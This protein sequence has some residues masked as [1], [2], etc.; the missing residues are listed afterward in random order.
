MA[1]IEQT[2][3]EGLLTFDFPLGALSSK[4]DEWA[5]YRR[6][7]NKSFG[8][9]KAVDIVFADNAVGWLIE[10]KDYRAHSRTKAID[11]AD[12]IA[13]KVR[14]TL[15][16]L[17]SANISANDADEKNLASRLLLC[18]RLRVVLHIEQ[19]ATQSK[20]RPTAI[21]PAAVLLKLKGRVKS[22][23][24]YPCVVDQNSLKNAMSWTVQ[25]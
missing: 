11:L 3:Q 2:I 7:F 25:G 15:A 24:P 6:Q 19:P 1:V 8:G 10:I 17:V 12:E 21:D 4:Y 5:H 16:G 20:L 23:D 22:V 13:A 14:D 9:T 18:T